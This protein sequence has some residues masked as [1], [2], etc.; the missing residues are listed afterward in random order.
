ML[1]M[2]HIFNHFQNLGKDIFFYQYIYYLFIY[3]LLIIIIFIF[4]LLFIQDVP[5]SDCVM[6]CQLNYA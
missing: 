3:I 4:D 2:G 1:F 5:I 6:L